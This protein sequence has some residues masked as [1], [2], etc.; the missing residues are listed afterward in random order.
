M[1]RLALARNIRYSSMFPEVWLT[2]TFWRALSLSLCDSWHLSSSH[3]FLV[4][5]ELP[6]LLGIHCVAMLRR[7]F[8]KNSAG[9]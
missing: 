9:F 7:L 1:V 2:L 5:P 3:I 8:V 6:W 4:L